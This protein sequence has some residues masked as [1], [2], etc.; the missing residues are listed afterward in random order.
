MWSWWHCCVIC[1]ETLTFSRANCAFLPANVWT[2]RLMYSIPHIMCSM[3]LKHIN[4]ERVYTI[5]DKWLI[6]LSTQF[7]RILINGR[8]QGGN[9]SLYIMCH[10][11]IFWVIM[12]TILY[13]WP[14]VLWQLVL[15]TVRTTYMVRTLLTPRNHWGYV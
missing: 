7:I 4:R 1:S 8:C 6:Y 14:H 12:I 11:F 3:Y 5:F 2:V 15:S 9:T 10:H 13:N